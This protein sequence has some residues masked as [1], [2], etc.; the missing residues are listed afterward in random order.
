MAVEASRWT[1]PSDNRPPDSRIESNSASTPTSNSGPLE[2]TESDSTGLSGQA[3]NPPNDAQPPSPPVSSSRDSQGPSDLH[4]PASSERQSSSLVPVETEQDPSRS[5]S[6]HRV[7]MQRISAVEIEHRPLVSGPCGA[8]STAGTGRSASVDNL[9]PL[10]NS[11]HR[12][13][14]FNNNELRTTFRLSDPK[15]LQSMAQHSPTD[16][17][18]ASLHIPNQASMQDMDAGSGL[19]QPQMIT[20]D[21]ARGNHPSDSPNAC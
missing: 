21:P 19:F 14:A 11:T 20:T 13:E 9:P 10:P 2:I 3:R 4:V 16:F 12:P 8:S 7:D 17:S 5:W 6:P 18:R 15:P 1:K